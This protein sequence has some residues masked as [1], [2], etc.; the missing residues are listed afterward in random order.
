M[1]P[2]STSLGS[3]LERLAVSHRIWRTLSTRRSGEIDF[4]RPTTPA[5]KGEAALVPLNDPRARNPV[6]VLVSQVLVAALKEGKGATA[7]LVPGAQMV[8][9]MPK[10][11]P[12][13]GG[14]GQSAAVAAFKA[15]RPAPIAPTQMTLSISQGI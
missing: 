12:P 2:R 11:E 10:F 13:G 5:T 6:F 3:L 7:R 15:L 4:I 14:P 9:G 1:E 8:V